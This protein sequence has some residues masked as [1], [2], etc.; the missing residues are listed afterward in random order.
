M[1][2]SASTQGRETQGTRRTQARTCNT[3]RRE[4]EKRGYPTL[5][6]PMG[7]FGCFGWG[8]FVQLNNKGDRT[9]HN[10]D[11]QALTSTAI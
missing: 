1:Q 4:E 11:F 5:E 8:D 9:L 10:M 3:Q 6:I 7:F 2:G